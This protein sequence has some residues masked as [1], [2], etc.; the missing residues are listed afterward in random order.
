MSFLASIFDV[1]PGQQ[2]VVKA[3]DEL[4]LGPDWALLLDI[5][6]LVNSQPEAGK[7]VLKGIKKRLAHKEV[8]V[9]LL[10][11]TLLESLMKNCGDAFRQQAAADI[12]PDL[13]KL[14]SQAKTS[15]ELREQL[16]AVIESGANAAFEQFVSA[17]AQCQSLGVLPPSQ[18]KSVHL[19]MPPG[20]ANVGGDTCAQSSNV[21]SMGVSSAMS[22]SDVNPISTMVSTPVAH[23]ALMPV[24]DDPIPTCS[25]TRSPPTLQQPP[26]ART[27]LGASETSRLVDLRRVAG[28]TNANAAGVSEEE[29]EEAWEEEQLQLALAASL[30]HT[31]GRYEAQGQGAQSV[32]LD[33][34]QAAASNTI[35]LGEQLATLGS[36]VTLF[37]ECLASLSP[38]SNVTQDEL[39]AELLPGAHDVPERR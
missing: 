8:K 17:R 31:S 18:P 9:Q 5:A 33:T 22:Q 27:T 35:L 28:V 10:T 14:V 11:A 39:I 32:P 30:G 20:A 24:A 25:S 29:R 12:V 34:L 36:N 15:T 4:L 13:V 1:T 7:E 2:M 19:L 23:A 21:P 38:G 16:V 26:A 6:D 3:T 37:A